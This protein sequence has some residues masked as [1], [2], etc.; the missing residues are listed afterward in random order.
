[1]FRKEQEYLERLAAEAR[2]IAMAEHGS[3]DPVVGEIVR[4]GRGDG[5]AQYMVWRVRPLQLIHIELGDAWD[6][7]DALIRGLRIGDIR[8]MVASEK[9]LREL[10]SKEAPA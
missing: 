9:R 3:V 4:F 7:E 2:R 1:M 6:V 5:Y 10:F 8:Q